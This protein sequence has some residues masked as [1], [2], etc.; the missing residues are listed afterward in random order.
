VLRHVLLPPLQERVTCLPTKPFQPDTRLNLLF[1]RLHIDGLSKSVR[2]W[3]GV[4]RAAGRVALLSGPPIA[5][6]G[7]R[8]YTA[9]CSE[10]LVL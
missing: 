4:A 3:N 7:R 6:D 9:A 5:S 10:L 2:S 1:A 8:A